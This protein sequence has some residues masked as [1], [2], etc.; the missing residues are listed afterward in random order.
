VS[1]FS[2]L[3][4]AL[5][6]LQTQQ[7]G[8]ELA[9]QN[10]ANAN[11]DGYT[12]Q[13]LDLVS[14]GAPAYPAFW[15]KY[16]GDGSGVQ[17]QDTTRFRDQFMEI[18]AALEHGSNASLGV[19][20]STMQSIEQLFN[21]PSDT[22]IAQQMSDFW[23]GF[24]DVANHP[25]DTASRTQLLERAQTLASSFNTISDQ[26]VKQK[27]NTLSEAGATVAQINT[28]ADQIAQ[29]NLSIKSATISGNSVNELLDQRDLLANKLAELSG[30]TLRSDT[31]NQVNVVLG[32]TALVQDEKSQHLTLDTTGSPAVMRWANSGAIAAVTSGTAGGQL[33]AANSTIPGYMTQ[34][35]TVATTLRDEV[36]GL[37]GDITGSIAAGNQ[38]LTSAGNLQ[39]NVSLDGAANATVTVAGAD[40]SGAGGAT[41]LQTAMQTAMNTAIGAGNATVTVT[42]GG[43]SPL[44]IQITPTGSHKLT[45]Q[46]AG[47]NQGFATLLGTTG[48]GSDGV[49]GRQFFTGTTAGNLAL[50]TDVAGIPAAV[51][52]A[53]AGNG[54]LDGSR[55]LDLADLATAQTGAD[56]AYRQTIVQLGV[57]T[58]TAKSRSDIQ[59]TAMQSLDSSRNAYSGVNTDEEMISMV[60]FQHAYEASARYMTA[61]NSMLDTL[62]NHTGLV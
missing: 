36:N 13:R 58:Q 32:G 45:V 41:A 1:E 60:Q 20:S 30:G 43:G 4:T 38:D 7:R 24:D 21:E 34:L 5:S 62:I 31:N 37:H 17:V 54:P 15:S 23:S 52:A 26:L 57:D 39:F 12:R 33:T 40:F 6:A 22:G 8:L 14:V 3:N 44:A 16:V 29:L 9:G 18:Q 42:G 10:I 19:G 25:D 49:G 2:G 46:A 51:A 56:A 47:A 55:A 48:V 53:T 35:D 59:S 50:S 11:T 61:I 27:Q 28:T